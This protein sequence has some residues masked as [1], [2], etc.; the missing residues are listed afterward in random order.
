MNSRYYTKKK[1][2]DYK[3]LFRMGGL[4]MVILGA[5]GMLYIAFPLLSWQFYFSAFASEGVISPVPD[6]S[7]DTDMYS[8]LTASTSQLSGVDYTHAENWYPTIDKDALPARVPTYA[9]SIPKINVLD[10]VVS[11]EDTD[12][13]RHMVQYNS[14]ATPP[15]KG[16]AIVFGHSTL[17]QL[18][19]PKDYKTI[20]AKAYMLKKGD[21]I[22]TTVRG[23]TYL[24]KIEGIRIVSAEDTSI[25]AQK[26]DD[27]YLT[28]VTCTPP[29][30]IWKR[31][32]LTARLQAL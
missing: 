11:T 12:L 24:Y 2:R 18:Y 29:G 21:S 31:L 13:T 15:E 7:H 4:F 20:L 6:S 22:I 26:K 1:K 25:F 19:N 17:P 14:K 10:A 28:L 5:C 23:V 3:K 27:S 30:T 9:I 16:N 8:L 32:V